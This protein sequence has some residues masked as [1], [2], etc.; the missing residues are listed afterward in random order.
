M[1]RN[2]L[3]GV[4]VA[5]EAIGYLIKSGTYNYSVISPV[6]ATAEFCYSYYDPARNAFICVFSDPSFPFHAEG[7]LIQ[8]SDEPIEHLQRAVDRDQIDASQLRSFY[9]TG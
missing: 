7:A 6:P 4:V 1:S 5:G 9:G 8:I 3:L 2:N